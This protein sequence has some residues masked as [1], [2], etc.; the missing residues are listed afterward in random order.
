VNFWNEISDRL[1]TRG[2]NYPV[3]DS[4]IRI[5]NHVHS[6]WSYS[7]F[8]SVDTIIS[9]AKKED[10]KVMGIND[11]NTVAGYSEWAVK[12]L[13]NNIFPLFNIEMIGLDKTDMDAGRR[14]N[15][16]GNPGRTYISGKALAYPC[17]MSGT[18]D[19]ILAKIIK[20]SNLQVKEMT[21]RVNSILSKINS[22]LWIDFPAL[23]RDYT[24]GMVR[25]RHL[26]GAI[27]NLIDNKITEPG[28]KEMF[29]L[30][31]LGSAYVSI[32]HSNFAEVEN[33]LR[34]VLLKSGGAAFVPED[35][36]IF[37]DPL[38]IR[39]I[40][41]DAGGVPTYPFLA[42]FKNG[43]YTDFE[44][45]REEAAISLIEKGFY[46]VEFIPQRNDFNL[47]RDYALFL[48]KHGFI[49]TFGT[50]HNAPG[51]APLEVRAGRDI[52][53]DNELM[54]IC[55]EGTAI[56]AA[57]QY[58]VW[59]EGEGY[60]SETGTPKIEEKKNYIELGKRLI[61]SVINN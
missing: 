57:H 49:V 50:E 25:E 61:N 43:S 5:N 24:N 9:Q 54:Q 27:R 11:F 2:E 28:K 53:L 55:L 46:S 30:D 1:L 26:A 13:E 37:I 36:E 20:Q 14:I 8:D 18:N 38:K 34:S 4:N 52:S 45:N 56:L 6:P 19:E 48:Y 59:K 58:M 44:S 21:D 29:F 12:C 7:S 22:G 41:L 3:L 32:D 60:L 17:R 40:I 47:F 23:L 31:L 39:D 15:D 35:P 42:D 16:P 10:I 33:L 51:Y